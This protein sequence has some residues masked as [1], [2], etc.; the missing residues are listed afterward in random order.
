MYTNTTLS[1]SPRA[2][3]SISEN[4]TAAAKPF[5]GSVPS[6]DVA[7]VLAI[8]SDCGKASLMRGVVQ[9]NYSFC[10]TMHFYDAAGKPAPFSTFAAGSYVYPKISDACIASL[11]H[12]PKPAQCDPGFGGGAAS[13][14]FVAYNSA[15]SSVVYQPTGGSTLYVERICPDAVVTD[16]DKSAIKLSSL[17]EGDP[18]Q[19]LMNGDLWIKSI[20]KLKNINATP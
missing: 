19:L 16:T 14:F 17:H 11:Q 18:V 9:T 8:N 6:S 1:C 5:E 3:Y 13:V 15:A 2:K 7:A 10:P 12:A 4:T 20:S